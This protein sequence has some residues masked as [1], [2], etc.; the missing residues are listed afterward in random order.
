MDWSRAKTV[1]IISFLL[2]NML[3][4]FQLW[5]G[6]IGL[7]AYSEAGLRREEANRLLAAKRIEVNAAVPDT[8]PRLK[9]ITVKLIGGIPSFEKKRLKSPF[10]ENLLSSAAD[11]RG[12]LVGEMPSIRMYEHDPYAA[13]GD[14]AVYIMNQMY[15]GMPMF[16]VRVE[17]FAVGG[18][19]DAYRMLQA[20]VQTPSP[21]ADTSGKGEE[22]LS[23]Y[24]VLG[25]LAENYLPQ[26]SVI[27]DI[28]LGY[29]GP[30]F[31]SETQ[32]LAPYWRVALGSGEL[33]Y[34]HAIN[35]AV[36]GPSMAGRDAESK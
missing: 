20:E 34:V 31:E 25:S 17:L 4:G 26:G 29:H 28:Q 32:V 5:S 8:M 33:Y 16:E 10:D 27:T 19:V 3:L 21:D 30:I 13:N 1:L 22:I 7:D 24:T 23:A 18:S 36:E 14:R 2:L 6:K 9:E 12:L 11:I 15:N 35:G